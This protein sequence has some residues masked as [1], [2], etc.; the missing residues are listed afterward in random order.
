MNVKEASKKTPEQR[1]EDVK[2]SLNSLREAQTYSKA[3]ENFTRRKTGLQ[4]ARSVESILNTRKNIKGN[5]H[6]YFLVGGGCKDCPWKATPDCPHRIGIKK[7]ET[8]R[9]KH[10]KGDIVQEHHN[11]I[12]SERFEIIKQ[13]FDEKG[14]NIS[15]VKG[16][17]IVAMLDNSIVADQLLQKAH[18]IDADSDDGGKSE[19]RK[20]KYMD[21]ALAWKRFSSEEMS[22][23]VK[24]VEG[25]KLQVTTNSLDK[26]RGVIEVEASE[27]EELSEDDV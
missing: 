2:N 20:L 10:N 6:P 27:V 11:G 16:K 15:F 3:P 18:S 17:Q 26:M 19:K 5:M 25:S 21:H 9:G 7:Y 24:Q 4:E 13:A 23:F 1:S 22:K 14:G 12:C 8:S